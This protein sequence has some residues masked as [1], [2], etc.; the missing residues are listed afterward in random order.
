MRPV[1][2][3]QIGSRSVQLGKRTLIMGI[4]NVTPDSFSDGG[5]HSDPQDALNHALKLLD[6]GAD[7]LDI[8]GFST[9]PGVKINDAVSEAEELRRVLPVVEELRTQRPKSFISIDT[10][11]ANIARNAIKAGADI[12]NDVS[13]FLWDKAMPKAIADL[14]CGAVLMHMRGKPDE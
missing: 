7:I 12:I 3:W 4:V 11:R 10:F 14:K 2:D 8:G 13:G 9:R 5:Q 6:E 1:F